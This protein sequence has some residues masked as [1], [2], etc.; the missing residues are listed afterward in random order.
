MIL[1]PIENNNAKMDISR[2]SQNAVMQITVYE[3]GKITIN[4]FSCIASVIVTPDT[5]ITD[6]PPQSL[7]T[8][9]ATHL[10]TLIA[11]NP[12]VILIGTGEKHAQAPHS[13]LSKAYEARIGVEVMSTPAACK[14]FNILASD[15]RRV[16]AGLLL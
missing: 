2:D 10:D 12:E 8:L 11:L 1:N 3:A 9:D 14:T 7:L 16:V 5:L 15:G 13:V 4:G 6:W